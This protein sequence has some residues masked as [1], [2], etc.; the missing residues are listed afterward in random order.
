M[1]IALNRK[2]GCF[3]LTEQQ[4]TILENHPI[5]NFIDEVDYRQNLRIDKLLIA[6]LESTPCHDG[7]R[8][9]EMPDNITDFKISDYDGF[10]TVYYVVDGKIHIL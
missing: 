1:K 2:Y 3:M 8:I 4:Q 5:E 6:T 10:E 7:V 9:L